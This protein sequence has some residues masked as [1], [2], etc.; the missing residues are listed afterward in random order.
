MVSDPHPCKGLCRTV[1]IILFEANH[2]ARL[3]K[4]LKIDALSLIKMKEKNKKDF[5]YI[6]WMT[7]LEKFGAGT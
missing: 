3:N 7:T 4:C 2:H 1:G 5:I 6:L